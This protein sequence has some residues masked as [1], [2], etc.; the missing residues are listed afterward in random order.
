MAKMANMANMAKPKTS[1]VP[2]EPIPQLANPAAVARFGN[3]GTATTPAYIPGGKV[4]DYTANAPNVGDTHSHPDIVANVI[5]AF[6]NRG[7]GPISLAN[8]QQLAGNEAAPGNAILAALPGQFQSQ[9]AAVAPDLKSLT[10]AERKAVQS[11]AKD[12]GKGLSGLLPAAKRQQKT[13]PRASYLSG[14]LQLLQS[15]KTSPYYATAKTVKPAATISNP[16]LTAL[17]GLLG[18]ILGGGMVTSGVGGNPGTASPGTA[19]APTTGNTTTTA[20][21]NQAANQALYNNSSIP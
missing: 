18:P 20:A 7:K 5:K 14:V 4:A 11:A 12:M 3:I 17:A 13:V 1:S 16:A 6:A 19:N 15:L 21:A 2:K 9:M 8:L 10:S